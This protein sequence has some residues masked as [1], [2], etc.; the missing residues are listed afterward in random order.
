MK[1]LSI[2]IVNWNCAPEI[3]DCIRS[4]Q[5]ACKKH[6]FEIIVSDNDSTDGSVGKIMK[7]FPD[8]Q[9]IRNDKN[10]MFSEGNN[11][12]FKRA[13]GKYVAIVNPDIVFGENSLDEVFA[14]AEENRGE[15]FTVMLKNSDGTVQYGM[16]RMFPI[17][18]RIFSLV[19]YKKFGFFKKTA[20]EYIHMNKDLKNDFYI[21]Q[22]A[23][24]FIFFKKDIFP[25]GEK[26]F[27]ERLPLLWSDVDLSF[28]LFK[29]GVKIRCLTKPL[30]YHKKSVS[31]KKVKPIRY[32][33]IY[34]KAASFFYRKHGFWFSF[35]FFKFVHFIFFTADMLFLKDKK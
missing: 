17:I 11:I 14:K 18:G 22:V 4:V 16:H 31:L 9:I 29:A 10:L 28:R 6:L 27:D 7:D 19:F 24:A 15:I 35:V 34:S 25:E 3:Y 1:D 13:Q 20:Q 5:S 33:E 23:G 32:F 30:I 2:I 8:V 12:A 21:D 26:L